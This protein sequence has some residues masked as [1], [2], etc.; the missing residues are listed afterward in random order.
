MATPR[1]CITYEAK[2]CYLILSIA[3]PRDEAVSTHS[4]N[5]MAGVGPLFYIPWAYDIHFAFG[6][7]LLFIISIAN[8]SYVRNDYYYV[9]GKRGLQQHPSRLKSRR[10][11]FIAVRRSCDLDN[12][13]QHS[14]PVFKQVLGLNAGPFLPSVVKYRYRL[15]S[16]F[17]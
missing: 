11:V 1:S 5:Q 14:A 3:R 10:R 8:L 9:G 6:K 17:T 13:D 16:I 4:R 7:P 12:R 15:C 2:Q